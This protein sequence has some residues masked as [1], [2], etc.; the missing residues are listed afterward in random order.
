MN[1]VFHHRAENCPF[2]S[3]CDCELFSTTREGS[4]CSSECEAAS[5]STE[6]ELTRGIWG[7]CTL[8]GGRSVSCCQVT[9]GPMQTVLPVNKNVTRGSARSC[10]RSGLGVAAGLKRFGQ[11]EKLMTF[12]KRYTAIARCVSVTLEAAFHPAGGTKDSGTSLRPGPR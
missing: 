1:S 7:L 4:F 12:S 9:T 3:V 11:R 10:E 2:A 8:W 5:L 6:Y